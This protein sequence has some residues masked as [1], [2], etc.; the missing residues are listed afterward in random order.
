M[1]LPTSTHDSAARHTSAVTTASTGQLFHQASGAD[2]QGRPSVAHTLLSLSERTSN[3]SCFGDM[4]IAGVAAVILIVVA[5]IVWGRKAEARVDSQK[6]SI[7]RPLEGQYVTMGIGVRFVLARTG[8]VIATDDP[9]AVTFDD[10]G[11]RAIPLAD[12]RWIDG[13]DGQR[14]GGPW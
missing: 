14:L 6:R 7:L 13:P 3:V 2:R 4:E 8:R 9:F 5:A 1:R 10:D 11:V 12:I